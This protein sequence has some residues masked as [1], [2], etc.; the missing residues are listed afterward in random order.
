MHKIILPLEVQIEILADSIRI[1]LWIHQ[2]IHV[3]E[4]QI[5]MI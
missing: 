3:F 1:G 4:S 2:Y 5:I